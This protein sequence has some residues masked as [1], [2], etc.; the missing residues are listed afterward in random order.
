MRVIMPRFHL[1]FLTFSCRMLTSTLLLPRRQRLHIPNHIRILL[2]TPV[3][4]EK[5]HTRHTCNALAD[6]LLL[7]LI[8]LIDHLLRFAVTRK[9]VADEIIIAMINDGVA[10]G[11]EAVG[12]AKG[13]GFDGVEDCGEVG[14]KV[15]GAV[16]VGV[17]EILDV[18][19][20]VAE[21]EDV[22]FSDFAG[23]FDLL[24]S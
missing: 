17:A 21:E 5:A 13:V 20:K 12:V 9:V 3:T 2:N 1:H 8:R 18:F 15:E 23:D 4:T 6:P 14:V 19:R 16:V 22:G 11:S 10:K 7:V 24:G